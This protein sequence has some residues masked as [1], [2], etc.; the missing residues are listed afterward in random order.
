MEKIFRDKWKLRNARTG[1]AQKEGG[2]IEWE[3]KRMDADRI[4]ALP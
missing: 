4:A 1:T 2:K 3:K